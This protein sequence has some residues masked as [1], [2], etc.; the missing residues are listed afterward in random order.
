MRLYYLNKI[1]K[2]L[3]IFKIKHAIFDGALLGFIRE[4]N[5]IE[6]DWDAEISISYNDFKC[7]RM[8]LIERIEKDSIGKV[9][10]NNS[11]SN[12]KINIIL[13]NNFKYTIQAF[14]YSRDRK[15]IYREMYKYPAKFLTETEKIKIQEYDFPIPKNAE[16][17]LYLEYGKDWRIPLNSKNKDEYLSKDVYTKKNNIINL[18]Y[19]KIKQK[20]YY[21]IKLIRKIVKDCLN[22]YPLLEYR[23]G[24][25]RERLFI[26]Q[27]YKIAKK[28]KE[29]I[30]VEI[31]SSDLNESII[32]TRIT[33][34]TKIFSIVYEASEET[35]IKLKEKKQG[36]RLDNL[37]V[38]NKAI[39]PNN[40]N[41]FLKES[42]EKNLNRLVK[43]NSYFH[44]K[45]KNNNIL[46]F[47]Q[48]EELY[49]QKIHKIIKMDI[50]GL[51]EDILINNVDLLSKLENISLCIELHQQSYKYP[52]K[53]KETFI[54]LTENNF[55]I[56]FV[57]FSM[58]SNKQILSEYLDNKNLI[59]QNNNRYLIENPKIEIINHLV[60]CDYRIIKKA[61]FYS[62]KNIR[63]I[64][65]HKNQ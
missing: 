32:L 49:K 30:F 51:E 12:A 65:L 29:I 3:D 40:E 5:L 16:E 1:S 33:S 10:L 31:G 21:Y 8:K 61:P 56:K 14:H 52:D 46:R 43:D 13:D 24:L 20:L 15:Y 37:K 27:L 41:Y 17:L 39:T 58:F 25:G 57:E 38:L 64:T 6:W 36:N 42:K 35:C 63:S 22:R 2:I 26:L 45:I 9:S 60:Y 62:P 47:N 28:Y 55:I 54:Q 7:Y 34:K 44:S 4:G 53:L 59:S 18:T 19:I 48:I 23:L 11:Y 50:E